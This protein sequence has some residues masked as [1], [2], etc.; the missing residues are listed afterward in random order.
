MERCEEMRMAKMIGTEGGVRKIINVRSREP[1][2]NNLSIARAGLL[3]QNCHH[4]LIGMRKRG[5]ERKRE[6]RGFYLAN[7][8]AISLFPGNGP[9][10]V[11]NATSEAFILLSLH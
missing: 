7:F 4:L 2:V 1:S 10:A 8:M 6:R 3:T 5:R 11:L 9:P